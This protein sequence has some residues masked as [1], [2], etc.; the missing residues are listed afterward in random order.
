MFVA[1]APAAQAQHKGGPTH[2]TTSSAGRRS[3]EVVALRI[4]DKPELDGEITEDFWKEAPPAAD[5]LQRDPHEGAPASEPTEVRIAYTRDAIY[6][7]VTCYDSEPEKIVATELRRDQ[8]PTKDDSFWIILDT[9]YDHRNAFLL[10][11][12][13]LGVRYDARITDEGRDINLNWDETWEVAV[14]RTPTGWTAEIEIPFE[15]LRVKR[16]DH[17]VWGIDFQRI[18]R[19]KNEFA[20]WSNYHRDFTFLNVSQAGR[21]VGLHEVEGGFRVRI[22]PYI[23]PRFSNLSE[24]Q[25]P[26]RDTVLNLGVDIK[27]R[28]TPSLVADFTIH[29]DFAQTDVD[30]QIVNITR[31]PL[32]FPEKR[33]F[34]REDLGIFEFGTGVGVGGTRDLKLFFSRRIGLTSNGDPIPILAGAKVTGKIKGFNVGL[35]SMQTREQTFIPVN[36]ERVTVP[37][38]NFTVV[39]VKR[40]VFERSSIGA[41]FTNRDSGRSN[42]HNR[43]IGADAEFNFQRNFHIQSF[44]AKTATPGMKDDDLSWRTRAYYESDFWLADV[45]Y[46]DVGANF[47]PEIG[48]VPRRDQR[49]VNASFGVKPRPRRGPIRQFSISSRIDYTEN[50]DNILESRRWHYITVRTFFH[51]GDRLVIDQHRI[52][53][54][55]LRPFRI[56]PN[57]TIPTGLYRSHDIRIEYQA[58]PARRI[59]GEE[60]AEFTREWGFFGGNRTALTLF[61]EVKV[62][63][64]LFIGLGYTLDDVHLPQGS[65]NAHTVN[66]RINYSFSNKLLTSVTITSNSVTHIYNVRFRL[67]YIFRQNDNFF[68]V[69]DEG[70]GLD[71]RSQRALTAKFTYSFDF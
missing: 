41:M 3:T 13:P 11:T 47:N 49:T 36:E 42:D 35:I 65:F 27:Y 21:L 29:P 2:S 40:D 39:R 1:F 22:K 17:Q 7:G 64:N 71:G 66:S 31:F 62:S 48:F 69:Y 5:F 25:F 9:F 23:A 55:L 43:A 20:Y 34:F 18:I 28:I 46:L 57:M 19:R 70:R 37:G 8:D 53:E 26:G 10:A 56:T 63:K 54:H 68:L 30:Q 32:F 14:R 15:S 33:E 12:N 6:F 60:F 4:A 61:P 16:S 38:T 67:N 58:S 44:I 50:H 45:A 24:N 52:L 59:A 51:S